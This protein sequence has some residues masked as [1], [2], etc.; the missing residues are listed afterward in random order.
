MGELPLSGVVVISLEQALAAPFATRQLADLG[1][2]VIKVERRGGGD[3]A[4]GYDETVRGLSSA[5]AWLN[6][7][8]ESITLDLKHPGGRDVL[9]RLLANADVFVQNLAPGATR[10]L[11]LGAED[12][13]SVNPRL[14]VCDISGYGSTGPYRD[15]KAYDL[16]IQGEAGV[17]SITGSEEAPAKVGIS[18]ADIAGGMYAYSGI[19]SAL[20]HRERTGEARPVEVSLFESLAEWMGYPLYYAT[21]GRGPGRMGTSHPTIAPYGTF[22]TRD[23]TLLLAVQNQREWVRLCAEVLGDPGL[24]EDERFS[25]N[26]R[27]VANRD[28]L[29]SILQRRFRELDRAAAVRLLED[30]KIA[31]AR[32]N[33]VDG[34][35]VHEQLAARDRWCE[36]E[37]P[38]GRLRALLPPGVPAGLR[39]RMDPIP[40][41]GEHTDAVLGWL[42]YG[43]DDIDR[44]RASELI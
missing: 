43:H 37:S 2:R 44:M 24:A 3:F 9:R 26:S 28:A 17:I 11:G 10:R 40:E 8:K 5:F 33:D 12:L 1:A 29:E 42:G 15:K 18:V 34:L 36:V 30:A 20:L 31:Y 27:R 32:V 23:G 4:R 13:A 38:V 14:I 35:A 39:P 16:L 41:L 6:R 21:S 22:D 7:S 25:S 19:L